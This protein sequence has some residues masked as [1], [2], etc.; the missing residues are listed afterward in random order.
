MHCHLLILHE[1][2][3]CIE[4]AAAVI[5]REIDKIVKTAWQANSDHNGQY[6][7][8]KLVS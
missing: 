5:I 8:V 4:T 7:N 6:F 2:F 1:I 3:Q